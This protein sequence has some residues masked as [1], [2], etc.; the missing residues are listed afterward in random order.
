M[1][2]IKN[3]IKKFSSGG[4]SKADIIALADDAGLVRSEVNLTGRIDLLLDGERHATSGLSADSLAGIFGNYGIALGHSMV[5][6][7]GSSNAG[8]TAF[9]PLTNSDGTATLL[10]FAVNAG[11]NGE[12]TA[13]ILARVDALLAA[14]PAG[15]RATIALLCL[16]NDAENAIPLA[17]TSANVAEIFRKIKQAGHGVIV[18]L[19]PPRGSAVSQA[20]KDALAKAVLETYR[21]ALSYNLPI[22]D[23]YG[24]MSDASGNLATAYNADDTH[25][26]DAGHRLTFSQLLALCQS[27]ATRIIPRLASTAAGHAVSNPLLSG[28]LGA[29]Y[30]TNWSRNGAFST[31]TP[32]VALAAND[33]G[34][35]NKLT[36]TLD[37]T[38]GAVTFVV[39]I[40]M[41]ASTWS[42]GDS[43]AVTHTTKITEDTG[44]WDAACAA[45]ASLIYYVFN[46]LSI[47][48]GVGPGR[49]TTAKRSYNKLVAPAGDG[50]KLWISQPVGYVMTY[51]IAEVDVLNE[52]AL[53]ISL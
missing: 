29:N 38:G 4:V 49:R 52:T 35:G 2:S 53:G 33:D 42:A 27:P 34:A 14:I 3:L 40:G 11:A 15:R 10:Y 47:H 31:V 19:D 17:T 51:S 8:S 45:G 12:T 6:G 13:M 41:A 37:S 26:N 9:V 16:A 23:L 7:A 36:F 18:I 32:T 24:L 30:P 20:K 50:L 1:L 44:T 28:T 5:A 39:D 43:V 48:Q 46:G 25:F 21:Q 22:I